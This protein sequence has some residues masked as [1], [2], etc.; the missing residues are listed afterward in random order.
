MIA[1]IL[2]VDDNS[3]IRNILNDLITDAGHKTRLAANYS[4][5][6]AEIDKKLPDVA[7][8]DVKLDKGDNDG[9]EL[10]SHIKSK[11]KDTPVIIISGHANIEMA[12]KSLQ[13]GAFE[14]IE[15]PFDQQRL[16]NFVAR[17]V[18]NYN[19]KKQNKEYEAKLF[20]SYDLIGDSKNIMNINDQIKKISLTE[21]RVFINGP[22]GSGKELVARK[23]HKNSNRNKKPF[24]VLNGA[25]LD[26]NKYELELF[27]EE[28]DNG[29]I[30]YGALEKA[31]TGTLLIDQVSEI[32]LDIQ[33]KILRV[34]T[35]QKFKR[36][37]GNNDIL[38][39]VRLICSSSKDLKKEIEVGNFRE[40][41]F[42][43]INVFEIKIEP[44]SQRISDIPLLIKYF[45]K[46]ISKNYNIQQLE[47]DP[48][49]SYILNHDWKG[50]VRELRNL[51][52]RIAI[53]QP[54]T[55][56]KISNII[57]E[58]LKSNNLNDQLSE[59]SLSVP[60]KE[61]REKFEKEYLTIQLKKFNGN[62][63]KTANFVGM[64]R[65]ALH[66]KLK[67]LGIKEFN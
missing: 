65:S 49:N 59:N 23:I 63:S 1:E 9:I 44:L 5:A 36:I 24:V 50:N 6:I 51:I 3:D 39:D 40:D 46:T 35:D 18:E 42:H 57:K 33:S 21:T 32:P 47:I 62:I 66:R 64:E 41:L 31:N 7:I 38:V 26:S 56:D 17:A 30:S 43:R 14:F 48:N 58:S 34:L 28:K 67:G 22:S 15:K 60:L 53:L 13:H 19:L 37:N 45:S 10:L 4:Q 29:S 27:G 52:E 55:K 12:V 61:A 11:N 25:L 16:L 8:L 54:E 20:S 2:I